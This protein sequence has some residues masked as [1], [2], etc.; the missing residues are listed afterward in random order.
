MRTSRSKGIVMPTPP[1]IRQPLFD[2]FERLLD[3]SCRQRG[4][5]NFISGRQSSEDAT[6]RAHRNRSL[7]IA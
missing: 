3:E 4:K 1:A 5:A 6:S 2:H 7:D